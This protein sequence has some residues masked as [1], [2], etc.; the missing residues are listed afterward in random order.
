MSGITRSGK[1]CKQCKRLGRP[2]GRC[3]GPATK[4]A[5][6]S[7]DAAADAATDAEAP[8]ENPMDRFN[9]TPAIL[10]AL[11]DTGTGFIPDSP[12]RWA[13]TAIMS[14]CDE[15]DKLHDALAAAGNHEIARFYLAAHAA[16][17]DPEV[18]GDDHDTAPSI[19]CITCSAHHYDPGY[20][21]FDT[22]D[23]L[24]D[25]AVAAGW[26]SVPDTISGYCPT[27]RT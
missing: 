23:E 12:E 26:E 4:S 16:A 8:L 5:P 24:N 25:A 21:V 14:M 11:A 27:C 17:D 2:C 13:E 10:R 22:Q 6:A 19:T 3:L 9:S 1:P 7:L 18:M 15:A 20:K